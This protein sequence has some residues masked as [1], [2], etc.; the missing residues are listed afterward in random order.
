MQK[1]WIRRTAMKSQALVCE[2]FSVNK[3]YIGIL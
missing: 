3:D 2:S 1:A